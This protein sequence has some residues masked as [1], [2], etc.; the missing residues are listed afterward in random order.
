MLLMNL[1][2]IYTHFFKNQENIHQD[3]N[4][5]YILHLLT[6]IFRI[7]Y[8]E[9]VLFYITKIKK[10]LLKEIVQKKKEIVQ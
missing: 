8:I 4:S 7:F 3:I 6:S 9:Y 5:G 2:I 10:L 1:Y